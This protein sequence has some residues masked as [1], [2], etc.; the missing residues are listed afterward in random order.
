MYALRSCFKKLLQE[1]VLDDSYL[2]KVTKHWDGSYANKD[3]DVEYK[4]SVDPRYEGIKL[5]S[6][7]VVWNWDKRWRIEEYFSPRMTQ[8]QRS[9]L[10]VRLAWHSKLAA[11]L[12]SREL[13]YSQ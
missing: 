4:S 13:I 11:S 1:S 9:M 5:A 12:I 8:C 2:F 7:L 10:D 3:S 6:W